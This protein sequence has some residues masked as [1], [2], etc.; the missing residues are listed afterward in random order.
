M[1]VKNYKKGFTLLELLIVVLII[2]VL[3]GIALPQYKTAKEK[4]IMTEGMQ[5]AKQIAIAN[6]RYYLSN[7]KYATDIRN[8]DIGFNGEI[9]YLSA[10]YRVNT[11]NFILSATGGI[12][13][14]IAVVQRKPFNERYYIGIKYMSPD[15]FLCVVN[16]NATPIQKKLCNKLAYTGHL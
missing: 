8:L 10:A 13:D 11:N 4:T 16:N 6:Q 15:T 7:G 3:A 1:K 5:L 14:Y 9:E 2:G 12:T